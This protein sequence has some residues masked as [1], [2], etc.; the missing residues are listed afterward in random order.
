MP[1]KAADPIVAAVQAICALQTIASRAVDP[2][3]PVV[4]SVCRISA[5]NSRN[6][7][8]SELVFEGTV[9]YFKKDLRGFIHEKMDL[10]IASA[11]SA[12]GCTYDFDFI[13]GYIPLH[14]D[15]TVISKAK[16]IVVAEFGDETW[17]D[18][19]PPSMGS[20]D[21][22]YYLEKVPGC[23]LRLGL[24]ENWTSLHNPAFDF[25][26]ETLERGVSLLVALALG[27]GNA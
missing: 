22:A 24:G 15:K 21:F 2:L 23:F 5:G 4:V 18:H 3:D 7:I 25:N 10:A 1:H 17:S 9:R 27:Y 12:G 11:C 13:E 19:Q 6:V 14:N 8:P 20:E 26:D 16:A